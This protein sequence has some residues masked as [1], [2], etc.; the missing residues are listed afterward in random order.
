MKNNDFRIL[1]SV[2]ALILSL[3]VLLGAYNLYIKLGIEKPLGAELSA[4]DG[5][6]KIEVN[7]GKEGYEIKVD[8]DSVD[9]IQDNYGDIN[10]A[11]KA[12]LNS[13]NYQLEIGDQRNQD[14]QE[15]FNSLQPALYEALADNRF[16]W[17]NEQ[18][19]EKAAAK[20]MNYDMYIDKEQLYLQIGDGQHYL[21]E[22]IERNS[23][24]SSAE[25]GRK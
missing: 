20:G 5:V 6:K 23:S 18:L 14:L 7:K 1:I 25:T 15:L 13:E 12:R 9:N 17:L 3:G 22:V 10:Q 21:Y 19:A 24:S 4:L 11:L 2:A 8:L 16:I